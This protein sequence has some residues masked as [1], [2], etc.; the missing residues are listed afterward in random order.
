M[1]PHKAQSMD[2]IDL[3]VGEMV[4]VAGN[5]WDGYSKGRNLQTNQI[6]F[7]PSFKVALYY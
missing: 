6:G 7:Y 5:H 4:G 1:L 3:N 2:Q